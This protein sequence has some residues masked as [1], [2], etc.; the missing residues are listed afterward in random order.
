METISSPISFENTEIGFSGKSNKELKRASWLFKIF[1][2]PLL[3]DSGKMF[4]LLVLKMNLPIS[5]AVKPTV[6]KQ[7]CGGETLEETNK[8]VM[9]LSQ[10]GIKTD[11]AYSIEAKNTEGDFEH[12]FGNRTRR[13]HGPHAGEAFAGASHPGA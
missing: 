1:N 8:T 2:N 11:L 5:F 12:A 4:M 13:P 10:Y 6:F 3:V 7:F 9:K